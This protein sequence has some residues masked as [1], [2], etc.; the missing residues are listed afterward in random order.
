MSLGTR[1]ADF[2]AH[3][4]FEA[5][6]CG[7]VSVVAQR[8]GPHDSKSE[9]MASTASPFEALERL[10]QPIDFPGRYHRP[11]VG[12]DNCG[13]TWRCAGADLHPPASHVVP[14]RVVDQVR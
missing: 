11:R 6:L 7:E 13:V 8:D 2:D 9:A 1:K 10:E 3:S 5:G 12:D 14:E 4:A